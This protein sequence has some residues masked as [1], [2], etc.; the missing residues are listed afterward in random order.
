MKNT[1]TITGSNGSLGFEIAKKLIDEDCDLILPSRKKY[2]KLLSLK[3]NNKNL[4]L[5]F[6]DI[7][8]ERTLDKISKCLNNKNYNILIN[9]TGIYLKKSFYKT[10]KNEIYKMFETNFFSN[11]RLLNKLLRKKIKNLLVVNINSVAG[12]SGTANESIYSASKHALKGFYDSIEK[13]HDCKIDILNIYPGAFKSRIT[14]SRKD[15]RNLM[16]P[17]EIADVIVKNLTKYNSLK[18]N[19]LYLKRKLY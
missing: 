13:E 5:I 19:N 6:G 15:F 3:T 9:N 12:V 7:N 1:V 14:K 4:K 11:V 17:S 2:I 18:V 8:N 16:S 10:N